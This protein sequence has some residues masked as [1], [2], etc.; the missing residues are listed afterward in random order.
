MLDG[1]PALGIGVFH[2]QL[3]SICFGVRSTPIT[4]LLINLHQA[5]IEK[6]SVTAFAANELI[7]LMVNFFENENLGS[8]QTRKNRQINSLG[9]QKILWGLRT[10][11]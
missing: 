1:L 6:G 11:F 10:F 5:L 7:G 3:R 9:T 4:C 2:Q 8:K